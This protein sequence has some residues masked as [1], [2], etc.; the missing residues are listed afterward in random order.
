M[1]L[2]N[3]YY[4]H[5]GILLLLGWP[6]NFSAS[7]IFEK[8]FFTAANDLMGCSDVQSG[9]I[10]WVWM[11]IVPVGF[12]SA[13]SVL[14]NVVDCY[15]FV[16]AWNLISRTHRVDLELLRS[17]T[18]DLKRRRAE[19]KNVLITKAYHEVFYPK[20]SSCPVC[21]GDF[22]QCDAVSSCCDPNK[23][24]SPLSHQKYPC[25]HMFH[26]RCLVLW[27]QKHSNCPCCRHEILPLPP[28]PVLMDYSQLLE[29][30][31]ATSLS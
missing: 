31:T 1:F 27:L 8:M 26:E 29:S 12:Y 16:L 13:L 30:T 6:M 20:E 5:L 4:L 19:L 18:S 17:Q 23:H 7:G 2:N 25:T 14:N 15:H 24:R 11:T 9:N 21:L 28:K 3:N 22:Q 10:T